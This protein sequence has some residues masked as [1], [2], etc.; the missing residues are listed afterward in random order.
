MT[1]HLITVLGPTAIGKT[2]LSI[3]I[4]QTFNTEIVSADSRQFFKE[5]N[6]GTA[7]PNSIELQAAPHHFIQHLSIQD[8]YNVGLYEQ[9]AI[10]T[11]ETLFKTYNKI[12][13]V[14]GSGL[15]VNAVINGL[16]NFPPSLPGMR[17]KL[18]TMY[19]QEGIEPIQELLKKNDP[20]YYNK[21]DLN[22][23]QRIMRALEVC[24]SAKKPYSSFL[25]QNRVSRNFEVLKIGLQADR[26][27]IYDRIN[28]RVDAMIKDGL[29][30]EARKLEPY[31][32]LNALQTVGYKEFF[33]YFSGSI[34]R[35]KAI[36]EI[37][38]N[39]RRF[40]KRQLTWYR[41]DKDINWFDYDTPKEKIM[42]FIKEKTSS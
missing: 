36:A 32:D 27:I 6:I 33:D 12:I 35:D 39:T 8:F 31:K 41:K 3:Q 9:D 19:E 13:L 18:N 14:G 30:E 17:E 21:V 10:R 26:K 20:E 5:M 25:A 24:L 16:D 37:K 22:N 29:E 15:Y 11:L 23:P 42:D 28:K 4:A 7:V 34:N 2:A 40:A 1:N 38:K